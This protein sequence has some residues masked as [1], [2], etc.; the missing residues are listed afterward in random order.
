MLRKTAGAHNVVTGHR[1]QW[2]LETAPADE[3]IAIVV[4]R[5]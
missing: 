5:S 1:R 4:S 2:V 3:T